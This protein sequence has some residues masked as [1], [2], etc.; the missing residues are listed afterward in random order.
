[1]GVISGG[2]V[3]E[4][5]SLR[6]GNP[7]AE[8]AAAGAVRVARG[9]YSF[10]VDGGAVGTISLLPTSDLIPSGSVILGGF[11]EVTT[12]PTSGGAATIAVKVEGAGTSSRRRPSRAR[13]G[14][15]PGA[16]ASS[17]LSPG[18]RPSR[19]RRI[20]TSTWWSPRRR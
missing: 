20:G 15:P 8:G 6:L 2:K 18:R 17:R 16:R 13:R 19:P 14:A 12:A 5:A 3:I 7:A 9:T 1:M 10:A 4:G 11:V